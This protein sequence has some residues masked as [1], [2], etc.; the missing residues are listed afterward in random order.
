MRLT[1][2]ATGN[3][4]NPILSV[5]DAATGVFIDNLPAGP[6]VHSQAAYQGNNH[7]FVPI[8]PPTQ[9]SPKDT[10]NVTLFIG[11]SLDELVGITATRQ[12]GN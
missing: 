4:S 10:C 3:G 6:G 7:V 2:S 1:G 12:A 9:A 8:G 5:V 11:S